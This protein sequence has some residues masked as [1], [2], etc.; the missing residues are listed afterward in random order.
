MHTYI[1]P[2]EKAQLMTVQNQMFQNI[3]LGLQESG[4]VKP[5]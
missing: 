3:S 5:T 1:V 2:K 4:K